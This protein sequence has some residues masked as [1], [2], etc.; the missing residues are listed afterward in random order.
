MNNRIHETLTGKITR[1]QALLGTAGVLFAASATGPRP[2]RAAGQWLPPLPY[3]LDALEP[4]ISARTLEFHYGKHHQG[5]AANLERLVA[6][7]PMADLRLEEIVTRSARDPGQSGIFNNAAQVWN[8]TFFWKSLKPGGCAMPADLAPVVNRSFGSLEG[9]KKELA[10]A[11]S[12]QFGSGWA[13]LVREGDRL[14]VTKTANAHTPLED[15][16]TPL[17]TIDVWEHAYYL[18]YQNRRA[19]YAAAVMDKLMNWEFALENFRRG[20]RPAV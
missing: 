4:V 12:S 5:Y 3:P 16:L 1:R 15:G 10:Q 20:Q 14:K 11:A 6:G 13:W 17:V 8:H 18:D 2:A 7:T 19:D 9:L